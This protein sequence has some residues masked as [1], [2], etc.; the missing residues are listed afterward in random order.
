M[1]FPLCVIMLNSFYNGILQFFQVF[2]CHRSNP[3]L[4]YRQMQGIAI[5][6]PFRGLMKKFTASPRIWPVAT[7]HCTWSSNPHRGLKYAWYRAVAH[8]G[9]SLF[10][11]GS[12]ST[13]TYLCNKV[14]AKE[15]DQVY[16]TRQTVR[17]ILFLDKRKK[18]PILNL[19]LIL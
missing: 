14:A 3:T 18:M 12:T 15:K 17:K 8:S 13:F 5:I 11:I 16:Y 4:T 1:I 6:S 7:I 2:G 10:N 9:R 19:K